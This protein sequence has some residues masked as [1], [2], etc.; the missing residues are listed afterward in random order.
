MASPIVAIIGR[1]NVGKSAL[2]NRIVG[3]QDAIVH[4][5]P[6]ITRDRHYAQAEWY[7]RHFTVVDTGGL[8]P[9]S[10][11]AMETAIEHQARL[12]LEE[13][14]LVLLVF[15][16]RAGLTALDEKAADIVRR[17]GKRA[18]IIA[19]K[20]DSGAQENHAYEFTAL[21]LGHPIMISA[22]KGRNTGDMMD[23]LADLLPGEETPPEEEESD[24]P[25]AIKIALI[26]RPNVG[27]SSLVNAI[28]G[29]ETV[30]VSEVPGTTRDA[31][32]TLIV[33][34][35]KPYVLIDTAGLR[36]KAKIASDVEFYSVTRTVRSLERCDV[37][38]VL[39]DAIEGIS[40][41]E[42]RIIHE[43]DEAGKGLILAFNKWDLVD[44][45]QVSANEYVAAT[46]AQVQ[47]ADYAPVMFLSARMRQGVTQLLQK[48][49]QV[50]DMRLLRVPT[51]ALNRLMQDIINNH[52]PPATPAGHPVKIRY[53]TQA[54]VAPPTFVFFTNHPESVGDGY[55]RY[56][57]GRLRE[58]FGFDGTALRIV[59]RGIEQSGKTRREGRG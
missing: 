51:G 50:Q 30:I 2:F 26:G 45:K 15:D 6:G 34:R 14:D 13:A 28:V 35:G 27:K 58:M 37:A 41:Q 55:R 40:V 11:E 4:D 57:A 32:D 17:A 3:R 43:V 25:S 16:A 19:N 24:T 44:K 29:K 22:L 21:G 59:M 12:A 53:C 38:V 54:D 1:P 8:V 9:D 46:R 36:R 10:D 56:L 31:I 23:I 18:L 39:M 52:P 42:M 7:G 49:D 20:V 48:V 33:R 5:A 47:Y